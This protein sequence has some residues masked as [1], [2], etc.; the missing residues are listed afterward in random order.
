LTFTLDQ[1]ALG[2]FAISAD[3]TWQHAVGNS[4]DPDETLNRAAAGQDALPR[5]IPFNWD[6]RHTF[7]L[8]VSAG[9]PRGFSGSGVLRFASGQPYTPLLDNSTPLFAN[10]G[11]KP[12]GTVVDLRAEHPLRFAGVST[13]AF[14]RVFNAFDTRFFNGFVFPSSGS[15][16]YSRFS[17]PGQQ[18]L[19]ADPT[20]YFAPR[21]IEV[22]VAL[23]R[24]SAP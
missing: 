14:A 13:T 1:R 19:L 10:S 2:P 9:G 24:A 16:D 5:Q 23:R 18:A 17:D 8:T 21:R 3:Y 7:N 11:R 15:P 20:R 12:T 22:G 6:Q 4:S